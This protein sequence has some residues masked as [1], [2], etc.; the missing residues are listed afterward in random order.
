MDDAVIFQDSSVDIEED[1]TGE[2][3]FLTFPLWLRVR[4]GDPY[5]INLTGSKK[6]FNKLDSRAEKSSIGDAP[7]I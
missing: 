4:E 3:L 6:R 5:L 1:R 2:P 7:V